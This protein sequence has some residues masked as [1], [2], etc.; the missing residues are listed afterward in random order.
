MRFAP[1]RQRPSTT[2]PPPT[3]VPRITP[4]TTCAPA[5]A[6]SVAPDPAAE[7][8]REL[9][10]ERLTVEP[11]GIGVLH[12]P[13]SGHHRTRNADPHCAL[14]VGR[15]LELPHKPR[16]GV[17]R[18]RVVTRRGNSQTGDLMTRGRQGDGFEFR[19]A[20]VDADAH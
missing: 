7:P 3:P 5:A 11:G 4:N 1:G 8:S 15:A 13:C 14:S 20:R 2:I 9:T 12:E 18:R 17:E 16:D 19:A 6:P 10:L